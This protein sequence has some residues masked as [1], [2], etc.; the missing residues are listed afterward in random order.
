MLL[1]VGPAS[2]D[3][4]VELEATMAAAVPVPEEGEV[5]EE[6]E[7]EATECAGGGVENVKCERW[8][9]ESWRGPFK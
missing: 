3:V 8:S 4:V 1:A 2:V 9:A 6:E 7:E 5:E